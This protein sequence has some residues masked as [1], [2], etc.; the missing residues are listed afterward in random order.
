[1]DNEFNDN[2]EKLKK[3][4]GEVEEDR[5][6]INNEI[7]NM[8]FN[9]EKR[10]DSAYNWIIFIFCNLAILATFIIPIDF[11]QFLIYLFGTIVFL[12]TVLHFIKCSNC[13]VFYHI[14]CL[15]I[16]Y[17]LMYGF[18][19][20]EFFEYGFIALLFPLFYLVASILLIVYKKSK[21]RNKYLLYLALVFFI[22]AIILGK[23]IPDTGL[24]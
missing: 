24:F 20:F 17:V 21:N 15:F 8:I 11:S 5:K 9:L 23:F 22:V 18:K 13:S 6:K 16:S 12:N 14:L 19:F 3:L 1:M 4:Y 10:K 2:I 7:K